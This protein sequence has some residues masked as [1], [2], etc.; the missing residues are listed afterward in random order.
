MI[1]GASDIRGNKSKIFFKKYN[2]VSCLIY[3]TLYICAA[4][5][6]KG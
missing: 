5:R 2:R 3:K 4:F 1:I 6:N